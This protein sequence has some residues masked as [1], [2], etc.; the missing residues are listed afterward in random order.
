MEL[1]HKD[2]SDS[3]K[4]RGY[5]LILVV[6]LSFWATSYLVSWINGLISVIYFGLTSRFLIFFLDMVIYGI[7]CLLIIPRLWQPDGIKSVPH[8][9]RTVK[10]Y[11]LTPPKFKSLLLSICPVA[12]FLI[13]NAIL[14]IFSVQTSFMIQNIFNDNLY[15]SFIDHIVPAIW[16]EIVFRGVILII[17]IRMKV[18]VKMAI[19]IDGILFGLVHYIHFFYEASIIDVAGRVI[20]TLCLGITL[21]YLYFK[22][23]SLIPCILAHYL[24][25]VMSFLVSIM[26]PSTYFFMYY[27]FIS[28]F[29]LIFSILIIKITIGKN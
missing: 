26:I 18:K 16:E 8:Y 5:L 19:G 3:E 15:F 1:N 10:I 27:W 11:N 9:L 22:T 2:V 13:G 28:L 6:F 7:L 21:A 29:I 12:L 25:N 14:S 23:Q 20:Y 24:N 17:L 4:R